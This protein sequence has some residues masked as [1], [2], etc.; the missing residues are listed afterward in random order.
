ME[1]RAV[2]SAQPMRFDLPLMEWQP[3]TKEA[4]GA[5]DE[6]LTSGSFRN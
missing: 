3:N 4:A 6:G 5:Y 1:T 2:E